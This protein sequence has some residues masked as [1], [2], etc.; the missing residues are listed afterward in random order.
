MSSEVDIGNLAL[1]HIGAH[2]ISSF[3]DGSKEAAECSRLYA[4]ARDAVLAAHRWGFANKRKPLALTSDTYSGWAYAYQQPID[5]LVPREIFN[6]SAP[7]AEPV[8]DPLT[9]QWTQIGAIQF[10]QAVND[11]LTRVILLTDKE[12]AELIYTA[13]VVSPMLFSALFVDALGWRLAS[14]LAIPIRGKE[15]LR[16]SAKLQYEL[17][18]GSAK[19]VDANIDYK[20]PTDNSSLVSARL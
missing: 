9:G 13:A 8:W 2:S 17:Q 15:S 5:C 16:K 6:D 19:R 3:T 18:I 11:D 20:K 12:S 14:D 10:E 1:S 4:P 7:Q